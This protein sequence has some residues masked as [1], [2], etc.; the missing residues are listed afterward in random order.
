MGD[1]AVLRHDLSR[2]RTPEQFA[3]ALTERAAAAGVT[4]AHI[5][6]GEPLSSTTVYDAFRGSRVPSA[7]TL[8]VILRACGVPASAR[9]LWLQTGDRL[10]REPA[11]TVGEL[12][13]VDALGIWEAVDPEHPD[14]HAPTDLTRYVLRAHDHALRQV[15][16]EHD[17]NRLVVL[18][19]GAATGKT[20]A[21]Y[22]GVKA[23]LPR[24]PVFV[25]DTAEGLLALLHDPAAAGVVWVDGVQDFLADDAVGA[26]IARAMRE[27]LSTDVPPG[28]MTMVL[29][30]TMSREHE[31]SPLQLGAADVPPGP[32]RA[33]RREAARL[34]GHRRTTNVAVP[35]EFV[36]ETRA[37]LD[38]AVRRDPRMASAVAGGSTALTQNLTGGPSLVTR[39]EIM[40]GT[41]AGLVVTLAVDASRC[42]HRRPLPAALLL[43]L[44]TAH[45]GGDQR[46]SAD[47]G[48]REA[49]EPVRGARALTP[50]RADDSEETAYR[51]HPYLVAHLA[52]D[53]APG[54]EL[55]TMV[56]DGATP[57]QLG[58][59]GAEAERR[60]L[61]AQAETAFRALYVAHPVVGGSA[62]VEFL[63]DRGRTELAAELVVETSPRREPLDALIRRLDQ[64]GDHDGAVT[65]CRRALAAGHTAAAREHLG[66]QLR[67]RDEPGDRVEAVEVLG[68][69]AQTGDVTC[70]DMLADLLA[71]DDPERVLALPVPDG[72]ESQA[73][74]L[75]PILARHGQVDLAVELVER[76]LG[77][78]VAPDSFQLDVERVLD[79]IETDRPTLLDAL[80]ASGQH[81]GAVRRVRRRDV[82]AL[83]PDTLTTRCDDGD[84]EARR[85]RAERLAALGDTRTLAELAAAG[86][87][88]AHWAWVRHLAAHGEPDEAI[89]RLTAWLTS[90]APEPSLGFAALHAGPLLVELV[91]AH[92]DDRA[93]RDLAERRVPGVDRPLAD[94]WYRRADP[95]ALRLLEPTSDRYVNRRIAELLA[96]RGRV[97][98]LETMAEYSG[99]AQK[100]LHQVRIETATEQTLDS[101]CRRAVTGDGV[102]AAAVHR[103][104]AAHPDGSDATAIRRWGL[105]PDGS[106]ARGPA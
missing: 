88:H 78:G 89:D 31:W 104:L 54:A 23:E 55:W 80:A 95:E 7:A 98:E 47:D 6:N 44:L 10:R 18:V 1:D 4:K 21:A 94:H 99:A 22:E 51:V 61:W 8:G 56:I 13:P 26:E 63:H 50:T 24:W 82:R 81:P 30:A 37:D 73:W 46:A 28:T 60:L 65:V 39:H 3:Q 77:S 84:R 14:S 83:G 53:R 32:Q 11:L 48:L 57:S 103:R 42:G 27:R 38:E 79:R 58:R 96:C 71:V 59:I 43:R 86:D 40:I 49:T 35:D 9:T 97:D 52:R 100:Q 29:L 2:V 101:L 19:G 105:L 85:W 41:P 90:D 72:H 5:I 25:P 75:I 17:G 70:F 64:A 93:L 36:P 74:R 67:R 16:R 15:L 45:L 102:A 12:H 34:L 69:A 76:L 92:R 68:P 87:P 62:L 91:I 33:V 20:R 66:R 106:I